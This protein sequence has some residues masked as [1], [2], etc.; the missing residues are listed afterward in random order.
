MLS[1]KRFSTVPASKISSR[2]HMNI[3]QRILEK[4]I[5]K[6]CHMNF[7]KLTRSLGVL[8]N[9]TIKSKNPVSNYIIILHY[10]SID[11]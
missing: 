8:H 3:G 9:L 11:I 4:Q 1:V 6:H 7:L 10:L 5:N 2:L